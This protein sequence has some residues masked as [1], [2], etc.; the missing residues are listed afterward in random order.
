M[1]GF[2]GICKNNL[3]SEADFQNINRISKKLFHRGP[4][5]NSD[6]TNSSKKIFLSHRRLSINDLTI[7]GIQP[8]ISNSKRYVIVFNGEIYNFQKL[9]K[10][11]I[12]RNFKFYGRS[13]TEVL[14][15]LIDDCGLNK[16]LEKINGMYSFALFDQK[17]NK[18]LLVRDPTGQKP[19]YYYK[20]DET[21][22]FTSE[23]RG[24]KFSGIKT[25]I[26]K[27]S[28]R[29]FFQLSY[30]PAPFTIYENFFKIQKGNILELNLDNFNLKQN[31]FKLQNNNYFL[32]EKN[33]NIKLNL[34]EK[35]F[36]EVIEDHLISD[37][38]NG[39]LLSGGIDSSIVTFFSNNVLKN[40]INSYCVK[41]IDK[42]FDESIYAEKIAKK[43]GTNHSTI[44]FS[45][46]DF[47][48]EATNIHKVYD[49]PFGDSSQIPTYLLFK[50]VKNEIKVALS[51]DGGDEIFLGY[52][53][54]LFLNDFYN[55]I[56]SMNKIS[57]K[58]FYKLI[59]LVSEK[60]I[61]QIGKIF[62]IKHFNLGN[63]ITKVAN[64][65]HFDNIEEF[66]FQIIRQDYNFDNIVHLDK[67]KN[68]NFL[69]N[70][71]FEKNLSAL[72]NFQLA[73]LNL[74]LPDD[75]MVKVDRASMFN[76]VE[77]RAPFL[78]NR[79]TDFAN[80]LEIEDK[81]KKNNAKFFLKQIMKRHFSEEDFVR[82]KMGFGNPI[83]KFLN[84]DLNQWANKK[85]CENNETVNHYINTNLIQ[86]LWRTHQTD[87]KDY[88]NIIWNFIIFKN[89]LNENEV[90]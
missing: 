48:H 35:L 52:N 58:I 2:I 89:W 69:D 56:K 38:K 22:F 12:S 76:S 14:L 15:N 17:L 19:L 30:V 65:L 64:S 86:D 67:N 42:N 47:F 34:F 10:E 11:L 6:W 33:L 36:S 81:I 82:P 20:D 71:K 53:R 61:N 21:F 51:G 13:D 74:Y 32:K 70:I 83:G 49:E 8:M 7:D 28:L 23:L 90:N 57:K 45:K 63:K 24:L 27:E 78:D 3:L 87:T 72:R 84:G 68:L 66:Y 25:I 40:K 54:Y 31:N 79:I 44:E 9:K 5:Q 60:K 18:I 50:S 41:S 59:N 39:T 4:N 80:Q 1:C 75:I 16:A 88:S 73:D 46:N 37:V 43:I 26:S 55:K 62:N 77:S 29:Y 85:I